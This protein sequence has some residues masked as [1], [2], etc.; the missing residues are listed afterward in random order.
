MEFLKS[1]PI[2]SQVLLAENAGMTF[3]EAIPILK[4]GILGCFVTGVVSAYLGVYMILRR[5]VFVSAALS[6]VSALGLA[7]AF[8]LGTLSGLETGETVH[9][10][11]PLL[12]AGLAALLLAYQSSEKRMTRESLLGIGY[13]L[14]AGLVLLILDKISGETHEIDNIL[15]GNTVFVSTAQLLFLLGTAAAVLGIHFIY[16]KPFVFTAYD[17]DTAR[18]AGLPTLFYNQLFFMT[19]ALTISVSISSIGALPV[20]GLMVMPAA[21]S[22]KMTHRLKSTFLLSLT[23]GGLSALIGFYLSFLYDL[24]TGAAILATSGLWLI[25]GIFRR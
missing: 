3:L 17:P 16:Y 25:I 1:I 10:A 14:P 9:H 13:A 20:F 18:A 2:L 23:F 15:F 21:A 12:F 4:N 8:L 22:L 6:Q 19:V 7:F 24:P 11:M 5:M